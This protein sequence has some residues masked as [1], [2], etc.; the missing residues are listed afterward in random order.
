MAALAADT[1]AQR[2]HDPDTR[3]DALESLELQPAPIPTPI[4]MAAAP[5]LLEVLALDASAVDRATFDR[6][7]L[8]LGRLEAE[9][10]PDDG[11]VLHGA[12]FGDGRQ[13]KLFEASNIA[14]VALRKPASELT[15][16]DATSY[17]CLQAH[18]PAYSSARGWTAPWKAAGFTAKEFLKAW[19]SFDPVVSKKLMPTDDV[20]RQLLTLLLDLI[21]SN[22]LP[23]LAVGGAWSGIRLCLEGRP[24]LGPTAV[25]GGIFEV[26]VAGLNAI[27]SPADWVSISRG[28]AGR[29]QELLCT[30]TVVF[31]LFPGQASRWDLAACVSSGLFDLCVAGIEAV[32]A[33]GVDG[34]HDMQYGVLYPSLS[35]VRSCSPQ[36]GCEPKIRA[37][38]DALG[39]C[40]M[41]DCD[42]AKDVGYTTGAAAAQICER[43]HPAHITAHRRLNQWLRHATNRRLLCVWT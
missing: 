29:A 24:S 41:H 34:L 42:Y 26:A 19:M 28:K 8:L 11:H 35:I 36:P 43:S 4:A 25:K 7:A 31:R 32:A 39:F 12:A 1:V 22:E 14:H 2:L 27:G 37:A 38:A 5:A 33:A 13:M 3:V 40:L 9:A 15:K 20:P 21:P 30:C 10:P 6:A 18:V 23:D 17:A 16:A